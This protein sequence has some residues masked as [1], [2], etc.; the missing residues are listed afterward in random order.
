[1]VDFG[2]R[3][4]N[5]IF[6]FF[7]LKM[8]EMELKCQIRYP[9]W[10]GIDLFNLQRSEEPEL[11]AYTINY[12]MKLSREYGPSQEF[13]HLQEIFASGQ[14]ESKNIITL[15]GAF[16]YHSSYFN[17]YRNLFKSTF[18]INELILNQISEALIKIGL[19][20]K[21]IIGVHIRRGDYLSFNNT[22]PLFWGPD[23]EDTFAA[24]YKLEISS[25]KNYI[26]YLSSDDLNYAENEF[27]KR[28]I[29]YFTNK[30]LFAASDDNTSII[31]DFALLVLSD[32]LII[33][34]SSFS[35]AASMLNE[36]AKI[37]LR[38]CPQ[39]DKYISFD[40]WNSHVILPKYPMKFT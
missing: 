33:S 32:A 31:I 29:R 3:F 10:I 35:F 6:S 7:F 18:G 5:Q 1:M 4:G 11:N 27:T 2:G 17:T 23:I 30:N 38:P 36:K 24:L 15:E 21:Y 26:V 22:H 25:L 12:E 16:Q 13:N 37:N 19:E 14:L 8:V 28:N 9:Y 34:N 40:P 39:L 20:H